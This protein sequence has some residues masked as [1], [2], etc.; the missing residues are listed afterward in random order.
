MGTSF[1]LET[2]MNQYND[3][4]MADT[5]TSGKAGKIIHTQETHSEQ[6]ITESCCGAISSFSRPYTGLGGSYSIRIHAISKPD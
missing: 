6:D 3:G 1:H 2:I 4:G 5:T